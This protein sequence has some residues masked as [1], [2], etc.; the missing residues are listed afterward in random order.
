MVD[1]AWSQSHLR[2]FKAPAFTEQHVFFRYADVVKVNV[3]VTM[4]GIVVAENFHAF[5]DVHALGIDRHKDLRL[6]L[7]NGRV[8]AGLNHGD[9]DFAAWVAGT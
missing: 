5:E 7:V 1:A 6:L 3:H 4:R 8:W 2:D 9:H